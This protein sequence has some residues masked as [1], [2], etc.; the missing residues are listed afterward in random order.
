MVAMGRVQVM[1]SGGARSGN[2]NLCGLIEEAQ[3]DQQRHRGG[4]Q[5][6]WMYEASHCGHHH[7][8]EA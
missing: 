7:Q 6:Q 3:C 2:L 1:K 8:E 5:G 4:Y